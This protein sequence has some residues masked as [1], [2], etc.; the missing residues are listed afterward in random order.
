MTRG[1]T[2]LS[3]RMSQ[4][5][6]GGPSHPLSSLS[7]SCPSC[8]GPERSSHLLGAKMLCRKWGSW[9][10]TW[11]LA[12]SSLSLWSGSIL[13][14]ENQ[15]L[16]GPSLPAASPQL[17]PGRCLRRGAGWTSF[18][19]G[20]AILYPSL[21]AA[22]SVWAVQADNVEPSL[23]NK[24]LKAQHYHFRKPLGANLHRNINSGTKIHASGRL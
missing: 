18:P 24:A 16:E 2:P 13:I 12:R 8:R 21:S 5:A 19:G 22:E 23:R 14:L 6:L 15:R 3:E 11:G 10:L 9:L 7:T 17:S 4:G 1:R 20:G